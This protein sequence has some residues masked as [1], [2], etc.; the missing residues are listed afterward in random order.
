MEAVA[1]TWNKKYPDCMNRRAENRDIISPMFKFSETVRKVLYSTNATVA[2]VV[3]TA[4]AASSRT[5]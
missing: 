2:T 5:I 4:V 3:L 1:K